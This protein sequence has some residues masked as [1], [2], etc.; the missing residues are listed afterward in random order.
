MLIK[1]GFWAAVLVAAFFIVFAIVRAVQGKRPEEI[2]ADTPVPHAAEESVEENGDTASTAVLEF[3]DSGSNGWN[4]SDSGWWYRNPDGTSYVNGWKTIEGVQYYFTGEGYMATGWVDVG[5]GDYRFF[6]E[7]GIWQQDVHQKLIALTFDDGPD[8]NTMRILDILDRYHCKATFFVVGSMIRTDSTTLA[9][10]Q[11]AA[12][13]GMEIG[14]HTYNHT[15]LSHVSEDEI[16]QTMEQSYQ[17]IEEAIGYRPTIMRPPGGGVND[18][19]RAT[20]DLP[21]I[22]WDVDTLDWDTRDAQST[23]ESVMNDSQEGSIVL[24]HD[25]YPTTADAVEMIIPEL[26]ERGYW[27]VTVS[28]LAAYYDYEPAAGQSYRHFYPDHNKEG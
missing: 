25:I 9:A 5:T 6:D 13:D 20:V 11:R 15:V 17:A 10:I 26:I 1:I 21:M 7:A 12:A 14:S 8:H 23:Y 18:T 3:S 19:V 28:E 24:M 4:I 16:R 2:T 27:P 22:L